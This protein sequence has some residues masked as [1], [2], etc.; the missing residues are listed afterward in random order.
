MV[1]WARNDHEIVS[2]FFSLARGYFF[3]LYGKPLLK[4]GIER[5]VKEGV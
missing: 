5:P 4:I 3:V 2:F 1:D